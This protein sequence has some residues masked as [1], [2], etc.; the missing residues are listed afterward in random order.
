MAARVA[1]AADA[2]A[3][4]AVASELSDAVRELLGDAV[5][6]HE[7]RALA[8]LLGVVASDADRERIVEWLVRQPPQ[9]ARMPTRASYN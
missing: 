5:S 8:K 3:A 7:R 2:P 4:G 6:P 9:K 1:P